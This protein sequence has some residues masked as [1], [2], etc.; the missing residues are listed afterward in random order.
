MKLQNVRRYVQLGLLHTAV[1]LTTLPIDDTL[2]RVMRVELGLSLF[3]VTFL[4][5]LPYIFAPLQVAVG[6]LADRHPIAGRRRTPYILLGLLAG[7]G[8]VALLPVGLYFGDPTAEIVITLLG[9]LLWGVGYNFTAV[10]YFS[11]AS[12]LFGE[13]R[14]SRAV[15]VMYFMM[16]LSVIIA[17]ISVSR[18]LSP[19]TPETL[20]RAIWSV[21]AVALVLGLIGLIGLEPRATAFTPV[22][23]FS[24]RRFR[25]ALTANPTARTFFV[26]MLVLLTAILGQD[27]LIEPFA[28]QTL[29]M[30]V[31]ESTRLRSIYGACFLVALVLAALAERFLSKRR[32]AQAA[33]VGG[34]LAFSMIVAS[35]LVVSPPLFYAG[36]VL[37]GLAI[38]VSTVANHS[39]MLDMTTPQSVG[40]FIGAWGMATSLARLTGGLLGG[41]IGD[42]TLSLTANVG[43]SYAFV[44]G[45][46]A[47]LLL[48]SLWLL[49]SVDVG[50][51]RHQAAA[52]SVAERAAAAGGAS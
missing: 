21:A 17:G 34:M 22:E 8:G 5:S 24:F 14:R 47:F 49:H 35:G 18:M 46:Q 33:S 51:F 10:S 15:A 6:A 30:P 28:G 23:P 42:V 50:R 2:N 36:L 13:E 40:L 26:Y 4:V 39:L 7:A 48:I 11:L 20:T 19:F 32:V 12:E 37:L 45:A 1:A 16:L 44:F 29:G 38:G 52:A 41:F 9:F 3:L 27:V 43:L 25:R 31:A